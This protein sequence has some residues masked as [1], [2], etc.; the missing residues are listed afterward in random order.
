MTQIQWSIHRDGTK[1]GTVE[2]IED[3]NLADRY[4]STGMATFVVDEPEAPTADPVSAEPVS[5]DPAPA[6]PVV[7]VLD[8][9]PRIATAD[10]QSEVKL[11]EPKAN[12]PKVKAPAKS[13]PKALTASE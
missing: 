1:I 4:V 11:D 9:T 5:A 8:P 2:D 10:D 6:D 7:T 13:Q 12:E 3:P